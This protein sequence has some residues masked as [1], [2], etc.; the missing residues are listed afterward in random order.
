MLF[1][2]VHLGTSVV[3]AD[4]VKNI[5]SVIVA[6]GA[7]LGGLIAV[8]GIG[9][10]IFGF[11]VMLAGAGAACGGGAI[12]GILAIQKLTDMGLVALIG[13]P[14]IIMSVV[15]LYGQPIASTMLKKVFE[16]AH[17]IR[18]LSS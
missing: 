12:A 9:G 5:K 4:Y 15:D 11:D 2:I 1:L 18:C 3:P 6:A 14:A 10:L 8:V 13:I 17:K 7:I 16:K